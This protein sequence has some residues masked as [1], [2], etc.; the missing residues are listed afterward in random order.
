MF[1]KVFQ[2]ILAVAIAHLLF[3]LSISPTWAETYSDSVVLKQDNNGWAELVLADGNIKIWIE[4][5]AV[6]SY[7][8]DNDLNEVEIKVE[9]NA[10]L[11]Q[12]EIEGESLYNLDFTFSPPGCYFS[13]SS[14]IEINGDYRETGYSASLLNSVGGEI[15]YDKYDDKWLEIYDFGQAADSYSDDSYSDD[16]YSDDSYSD[17][18]Y[19]DD[20]YF[21]EGVWAASY[22]DSVVVKKGKGGNIQINPEVHLKIK[23]K[24]V[25]DYLKEMGI[26]SVEI[27]VD[28]YYGWDNS[29]WFVFGPSGTFFTP[30]ELELAISGGYLEDN[31]LLLGED[32]EFLE[33]KLDKKQIKLTFFVHHFSSYYYEQYDY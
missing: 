12:T 19:S 17:D 6:T 14:W 18:S 24:S 22:F 25:D 29:I 8:Q 7:L 15:G 32:G 1:K 33:Y 31:M 10:E 4:G 9:L 27:T 3:I 5:K 20:S 30:G 2:P 21:D 26:Q 16:S 28:M 23:K 13:K 11:V